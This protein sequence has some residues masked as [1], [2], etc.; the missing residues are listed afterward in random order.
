MFEGYKVGLAL[1]SGSARGWAH[2]GIIRALEKSGV[3]IDMVAG[4]SIGALVGAVYCADGLDKLEQVVLD[5][6]WKRILNMLDVGFP[7]SGLL[8]GRKV[9][10]FVR[11]HVPHTRIEDM[12]RRFCAVCTDLI[13]GDE[14]HIEKGD[15]IEA[16]RA[17]IAVPGMFTP[18]KKDGRLQV[19]GGLVNPIPVSVLKDMGAEKIIG[20]DLNHHLMQKRSLRNN[21]SAKADDM[22]NI[23]EIKK[24]GNMFMEWREKLAFAENSVLRQIKQWMVRDR[25]PNVFEVMFSSLDVVQR[26][27]AQIRLE[28]FPPDLLIRP[29]LG[30][31]KFM[32]FNR[33]NEAIEEG[34]AA[35]IREID[36]YRE[37]IETKS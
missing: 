30:H 23:P 29:K 26:Q 14:V 18:V 2:I 12:P 25:L 7:R 15:V 4:C 32:D 16:V 5:L 24:S 1:G 27:I 31:L 17:S 20:V 9:A 36:S 28:A 19:D 37:R 35:V 34:Y 11:E 21:H 3:H 8:D 6:N 22:A 13:S 10:S 33:G